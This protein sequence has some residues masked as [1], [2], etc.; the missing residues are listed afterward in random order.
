MIRY[1]CIINVDDFLKI[2]AFM[3]AY[4]NDY[5]LCLGMSF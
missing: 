1:V 2:I 3:Y 5:D 4:K